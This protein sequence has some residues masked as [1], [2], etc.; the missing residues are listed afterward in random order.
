MKKI[1]ALRTKFTKITNAGKLRIY[2]ETAVA[3]GSASVLYGSP[4][5]ATSFYIKGNNYAIALATSII[6]YNDAPSKTNLNV[7]KSKMANAKAWLN[8]Y[9]DLVEPI[10]NDPSNCNTILEAFINIGL[11]YLTPRKLVKG[12][13]GKPE[14]PKIAGSNK[15]TGRFDIKVLNG[16][17]FHPTQM[18]FIAIEKSCMAKVSI[19]TDMLDI[20][21]VNSGHIVFRSLNGKGKI[22]HFSG[23]KPGVDYDV[24]AFSQNSNKNCSL[25][26][27][28]YILKG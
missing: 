2:I 18:N 9:A 11:S 25:I 12:T 27:V 19:K 7:V 17:G 10:A 21:F 8:S 4:A 6:K 13:K 23:M 3:K 24:Y 22:A 16:L 15:G 20:V 5:I 1:L 28:V 26:S 14:R